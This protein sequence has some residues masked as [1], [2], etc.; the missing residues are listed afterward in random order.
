LLVHCFAGC[1]PAEILAAV[2]LELSDLFPDKPE[3]RG[4]L[5]RGERWIPRDVLAAVAYEAR[6]AAIAADDMAAGRTLDDAERELLKRASIRL[7][8]A[9]SEVGR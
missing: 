6:L 9:A 4:P 2:G 3:G 8:N 1:A 5:R 7:S